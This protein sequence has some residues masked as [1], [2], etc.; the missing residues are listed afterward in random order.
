MELIFNLFHVLLRRDLNEI[1]VS[2]LPCL[3]KL[4]KRQLVK[5]MYLVQKVTQDE[6]NVNF[7]RGDLGHHLSRVE[8]LLLC[9][10][11]ASGA[12]GGVEVDLL[13]RV[14]PRFVQNILEV[15]LLDQLHV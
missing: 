3:R 14:I 11:K 5:D 4:V 9:D 1:A 12:I 10:F 15:N 8:K 13:K 7:E 6:E 2:H